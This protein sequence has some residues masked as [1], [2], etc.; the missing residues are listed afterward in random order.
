MSYFPP[1]MLLY[2]QQ[3]Q[4]YKGYKVTKVTVLVQIFK[5]NSGFQ[6]FRSYGGYGGLLLMIFLDIPRV[7]RLQRLRCFFQSFKR[8]NQGYKVSEV[9]RVTE[10]FCWW[11]SLTSPELQGYEGYGVFLSFKFST[12]KMCQICLHVLQV[13]RLK[14]TMLFQFFL[15][16][17]FKVTGLR[18]YG[19]EKCLIHPR[20]L[21]YL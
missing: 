2:P 11:F 18:G 7:T 4:G 5:I 9:T 8:S 21:T 6:G 3:E 15:T 12:T 19:N 14:V 1:F 17:T 10:G 13:T 16:N 20:N